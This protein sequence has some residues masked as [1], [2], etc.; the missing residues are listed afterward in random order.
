MA[1]QASGLTPS[2]S[3]QAFLA[4]ASGSQGVALSGGGHGREKSAHLRL[5]KALF[6]LAAQAT[7][8]AGV[9]RGRGGIDTTLVLKAFMSSRPSHR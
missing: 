5:L 3:L 2:V 7:C 9:G 6:S 8:G 1:E 4:G